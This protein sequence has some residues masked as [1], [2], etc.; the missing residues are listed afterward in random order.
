LSFLSKTQAVVKLNVIATNKQRV[1]EKPIF[2]GRVLMDKYFS[3][4]RLSILYPEIRLS[5]I[6][7]CVEMSSFLLTPVSMHVEAIGIWLKLSY[8]WHYDL[9]IQD[10]PARLKSALL[11]HLLKE[12]GVLLSLLPRY[13]AL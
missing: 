3:Y 12:R 2:F 5:C 13:A 4:F 9:T 6:K 1:F 10:R 7:I 11:A 8:S